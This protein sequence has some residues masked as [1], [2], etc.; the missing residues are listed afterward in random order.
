MATSQ[1]PSTVNPSHGASS[2]QFTVGKLDAG[3][4]ML[5]TD[6]NHLIEFPSLLLPEGVT[7][8][9]II[10]IE[11]RQNVTEELRQREKFQALQEQIVQEFGS[12]VP[13]VPHLNVRSVT[14]TAIT[15][16]WDPLVL[17]SANLHQLILY[18]DGVKLSQQIPLVDSR[19][20]S[21]NHLFKVSGLDVNHEYQ[22]R[23]EMR[24][25]AGHYFSNTCKTKTHSLD[26]L[27]GIHVAFGDYESDAEVESLKTCIERIGASWSEDVSIDTTHVLCRTAR[28]PKYEQAVHLN[29]PI[30]KPDWLIACETNKKLQ[31]ALS[32]YLN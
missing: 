18:R 26:N 28:G 24:T 10:N 5:L 1:S 25:S 31:P 8:G 6:E 22:F 7:S 21:P 14:Q 19:D 17:Y 9:S 30:V 16:E 20:K 4:A 13:E 11:V 15:L 29:I 27:T 12:K 23:L 3:M 32:Y 2:V